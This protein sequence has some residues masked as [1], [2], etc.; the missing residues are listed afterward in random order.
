MDIMLGCGQPLE[1]IFNPVL[2]VFKQVLNG[3]G[4]LHKL[5]HAI[6][7]AKCEYFVSSKFKVKIDLFK[8][9]VHELDDLEDQLILP[10]IVT[11]LED[12]T[13]FL[14]WPHRRE[15]LAAH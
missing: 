6:V 3:V 9:V 10:Y 7:L 15:T 13:V 4:V 5:E 8:Q 1:E 14:R 12:N 11:T 2:I